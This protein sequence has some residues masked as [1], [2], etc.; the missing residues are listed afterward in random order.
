MAVCHSLR[1]DGPVTTCHS[2]KVKN[3][4]DFSAGKVTARHLALAM[5]NDVDASEV[6]YTQ[7]GEKDPRFN[8]N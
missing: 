4:R 1:C 3:H 7:A 8:C 6:Q 2:V 5:L